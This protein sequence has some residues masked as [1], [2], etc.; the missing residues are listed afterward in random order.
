M[1]GLQELGP[2]PVGR[3]GVGLT[4]STARSQCQHTVRD[5]HGR[6]ADT[7]ACPIPGILSLGFPPRDFRAAVPATTAPWGREEKVP[8]TKAFLAWLPRGWHQPP[9]WSLAT[10]ATQEGF[11]P[12][13]RT[14]GLHSKYLSG[15]QKAPGSALAPLGSSWA[16]QL[17]LLLL[18]RGRLWSALDG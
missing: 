10:A 9:Y 14:M 1:L 17:W 6:R 15:A 4:L 13:S 8:V 2:S 7:P 3:L 16:L 12:W 5:G 11:V 18:G